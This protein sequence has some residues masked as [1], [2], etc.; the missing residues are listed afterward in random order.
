MA[1]PLK[2]GG[3]G[4]YKIIIY[5]IISGLATGF[6]ALIGSF[7]GNISQELVAISLAFAAGAMLYVISGELVPEYNRLYNGRT[8]ALGNIIGFIIGVIAMIISK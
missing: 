6:G 8:S 1:I 4:K 2:Q 7:I 5:I 3:M